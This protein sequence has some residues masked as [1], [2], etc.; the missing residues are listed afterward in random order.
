M[1]QGWAGIGIVDEVIDMTTPEIKVYY[2]AGAFPLTHISQNEVPFDTIAVFERQVPVMQE[3]SD[4]DGFVGW[5]IYFLRK[6]AY[7]AA[8][9]EFDVAELLPLEIEGCPHVTA[10]APEE[11]ESVPVASTEP[12]IQPVSI[13]DDD[14]HC[15]GLA[16]YEEP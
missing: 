5:W 9:V 15:V 14:Q 11:A 2:R 10:L 12:V 3:G 13:I 6:D 16:T 4:D 1:I 8:L 7:G